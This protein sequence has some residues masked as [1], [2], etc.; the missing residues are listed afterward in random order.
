MFREEKRTLKVM[1]KVYKIIC[2]WFSVKNIALSSLTLF[3]I[4]LLPICYLSFIN[5]ASGDDYGYGVYT[6]AVWV[7]THSLI[8]VIKAAVETVKQCYNSWQGT[9]FDLFLFTLQPEV[10]SDKAYFIVAF[11]MLF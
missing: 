7:S 3:I 8:E 11:L 5:R 9:W 2:K 6:R 1:K 4:S 10:F